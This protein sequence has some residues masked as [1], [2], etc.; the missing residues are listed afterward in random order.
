MAV[1]CDSRIWDMGA[2]MCLLVFQ[3]FRFSHLSA[4]VK[5]KMDFWEKP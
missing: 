4:Q 1:G 2:S 5:E 3:F